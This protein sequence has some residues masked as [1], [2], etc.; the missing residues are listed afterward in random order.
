MRFYY[1]L[2]INLLL[3]SRK[4]DSSRNEPSLPATINGGKN[5]TQN[6]IETTILHDTPPN[7]AESY[8][9]YGEVLKTITNF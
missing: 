8:N 6:A 5:I 4:K 9:L 1:Q 2:I 7:S 3:Q